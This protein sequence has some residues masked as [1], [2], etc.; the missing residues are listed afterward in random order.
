MNLPLM[1]LEVKLVLEKQTI[2]EFTAY[3]FPEI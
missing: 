1:S 2:K 3:D